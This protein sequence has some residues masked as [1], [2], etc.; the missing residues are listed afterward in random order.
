MATA[1]ERLMQWLRDAHAA[2]EQA[3]TMLT[4]MA[5]RLQNYPKL[6]ARI[7]N[8]LPRP[9]VRRGLCATASRGAEHNLHH[10]GYWGAASRHRAGAERHVRG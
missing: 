1:E 8:I 7:K 4:G 3:E 5:A 6:S 2:E 10:Q 9:S